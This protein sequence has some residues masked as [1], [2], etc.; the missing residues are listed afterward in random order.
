MEYKTS[1]TTKGT[2]DAKSAKSSKKSKAGTKKRARRARDEDDDEE[3]SETETPSRKR[4]TSSS[5]SSGGK[6]IRKSKGKG[7]D[8]DADDE[9]ED[10]EEAE[11]VGDSTPRNPSRRAKT[12]VPKSGDS[13]KGLLK[14]TRPTTSS[15]DQPPV[16]VLDPHT[17]NTRAAKVVSSLKGIKQSDLPDS[18]N[19]EKANIVR[20]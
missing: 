15:A 9:E 3:D 16:V 18:E 17:T 5:S 7:S 20:H 12:V 19:I 2:K 8:D 13:L 14:K 10:G 6:K 4:K 1:K 11:F